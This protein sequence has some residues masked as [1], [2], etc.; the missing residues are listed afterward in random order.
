MNESLRELR[1]LLFSDEETKSYIEN[2]P[3]R[4]YTFLKGIEPN[5]EF[6]T[7]FE[8]LDY[9]DEQIKEY[10]KLDNVQL[11]YNAIRQSKDFFENHRRNILQLLNALNNNKSLQSE[12]TNFD[13]YFIK[14][15]NFSNSSQDGTKLLLIDNAKVLYFMT[16]AKNEDKSTVNGFYSFYFLEFIDFKALNINTFRGYL[17]AAEFNNN[18]LKKI[19]EIN[20]YEEYSL[21]KIIQ[22]AKKLLDDSNK[23]FDSKNKELEEIY[24]EQKK[25]LEKKLNSTI[26][27]SNEWFTKV[28]SDFDSFSQQSNSK[29]TNLE[30]L[31]REKLKLEAPAQYWENQST[32]FQNSGYIWG[33]LLALSVIVIVPLLT[34]FMYDTPDFMKKTFFGANGTWALKGTLIY[35]TILSVLFFWIRLLSKM[36]LSSFHLRRDA[37]ERAQLIYTYLALI[38]ENK[39]SIPLDERKIIL[40]SIFARA[41][42][43]LIK[44]DSGPVMPGIIDRISN[45]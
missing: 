2:K 36:I 8:L 17:K 29:I 5:K 37:D 15:Q 12:R 23:Y 26:S 14:N 34:I 13:N 31:Y 44:G 27:E 10:A 38:A 19:D 1:S 43:G 25:D 22:K 28:Q 16:L 3:I 24:K 18:Y 30:K 42:T 6:K 21:M 45:Q 40:Q 4:L 39:D 9:F 20:E 41:E 33:I 35:A 32:K 7:V 11:S